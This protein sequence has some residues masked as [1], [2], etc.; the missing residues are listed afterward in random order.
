[1]R[2][3]SESVDSGEGTGRNARNG[4]RES[5]FTLGATNRASPFFL[6][7]LC[8]FLKSNDAK[9]QHAATPKCIKVYRSVLNCIVTYPN[10]SK[11]IEV[12]RNVLNCIEVYRRLSEL[13]VFIRTYPIYQNE[14]D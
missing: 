6:G 12:Y 9:V 5:P 11:R 7:P 13:S 10:V 1:M 4:Y 3:P 14:S 2:S 8:F